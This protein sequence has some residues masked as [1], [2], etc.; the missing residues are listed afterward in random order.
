MGVR[1]VGVKGEGTHA[2]AHTGAREKGERGA[3]GGPTC[4]SGQ[5][6]GTEKGNE[7]WDGCGMDVGWGVCVLR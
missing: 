6:V 7:V 4:V 2:C 5:A 3:R 1:W